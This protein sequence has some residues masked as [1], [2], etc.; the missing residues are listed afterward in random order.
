MIHFENPW[1]LFFLI[2]IPIMMLYQLQAQ[3]KSRIIFPSLD[4]LKKLRKSPSLFLRNIILL[5]RCFAIA[6]LILSLTRPQT[7]TRSKEV[8]SEGID[9]ILCLDTSGSMQTADFI[10]WNDLNSRNERQTRLQ[11]VKRVVGHFIKERQYDRIGMVVFGNEAFTQ[12]PLTLDHRVLLSF[13]E[14]IE[15]GMAG[16]S[17]AIGSA[18]G[19]CVKRL[20]GLTSKSRV[21]ILLTD[22]RSN[23][24]SVSPETAAEVAK[25]FAVKTYT[26]GVGEKENPPPLNDM[27]FD[28]SYID[29]WGELDEDTL[30][31]IAK[32]TGGKY[33]RATNTKA[34]EEIY[35][36]IDRLEKTEVKTKT[37]MEYEELFRWFLLPAL[38]CIILEIILVN[39]RFRKIP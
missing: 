1:L 31:E 24:G 4:N 36:Q 32:I 33:F 19:T 9:I 8:L 7:G 23:A 39:T 26:I 18:L 20:K 30:K 14:Q 29:Q 17:T 38:M 37:Y 10:Y 22:G 13:L 12:C 2:I 35:E 11:V 25:M 27:I 21:V 5:L 15:I 34:L 28:K 3:G 6:L 16:H